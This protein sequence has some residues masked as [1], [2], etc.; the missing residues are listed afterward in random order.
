M[1]QGGNKTPLV[2][3]SRKHSCL[4]QGLGIT[5]FRLPQCAGG[6]C[7]NLVRRL[8]IPHLTPTASTVLSL[9]QNFGLHGGCCAVSSELSFQALSPRPATPTP[10]KNTRQSWPSVICKNPPRNGRGDICTSWVVSTELEGT[11]GLIL[12]PKN[13]KHWEYSPVGK[14]G[15]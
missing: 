1:K 14:L 5:R 12:V 3:K 4:L 2:E 6:I 10:T 8:Y 7:G 15:S 13:W 11:V 9:L